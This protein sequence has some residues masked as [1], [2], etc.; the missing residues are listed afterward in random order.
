MSLETAR[1][2]GL[3][4][5]LLPLT[6]VGSLPKPPELKDARSQH[7]DGE[8]SKD[9]LDDM[10]REK[11]KFWIDKQEEIGLDVLVDGEQYRGD[12][13]TFFADHL[14]GFE[15]GGLVRSYGNRYYR[16]PIVNDEVRFDE[17]MTVDWWR[18]AQDQTEK[19][20]K[21][22]LTGPYTMMDWSF[23]E[24]Y[25][26]RAETAHALADALREEVKALIEAGCKIVQIDEP[27]GSVREEE[28]P[29]LIDV[30][31]KMTEGLDAYFV[32]HMCYGNFE[33]IYPEM[34]DLAVDNIDLE[35]SNSELDMLDVFE[36]NPFSKD[37][38]FGAVDVHDHR[39]EDV[40]VVKERINSAL[41]VIPEEQV[42][43]DPDCGLKTRQVDEAINKLEV[44]QQATEQL[45]GAA[46]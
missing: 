43:V 8:I 16:K 38:S 5:P 46:V 15:I 10:A 35:L 34:L 28:I 24:H 3:D 13:A 30:M 17:P 9:E 37:L 42:W 21:G 6:S 12:M 44:V 2:K 1:E 18:F 23:N 27:A 20:V 45:R 40:D 29:L 31:E 26:N 22:I 25:P 39:I 33:N 41:S 19:P 4:L 32:T 11:T 7:S 14:H 36:E